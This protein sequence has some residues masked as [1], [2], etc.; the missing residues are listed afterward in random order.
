MRRALI[1][2]LL[3]TATALPS[4]AAR[5][6]ITVSL[7]EYDLTPSRRSAAPGDVTFTAQNNGAIAHQLLVLRTDRRY[8]R[9]PVED[10]VVQVRSKGIDTA[11]EIEIVADDDAEAVS[12][13]LTPGRYV[14]ICNIAG[15]YANG[16]RAPFEVRT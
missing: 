6:G 5:G 2:V 9:L 14:L 11:G 12:V 7:D 4:C 16:M 1:L 10:G 3:A 13:T 15:H 8:D